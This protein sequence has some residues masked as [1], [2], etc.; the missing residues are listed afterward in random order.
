MALVGGS[1]GMSARSE[2]EHAELARLVA[3]GLQEHCVPVEIKELLLAAGEYA[4]VEI[5]PWP[6]GSLLGGSR[7]NRLSCLQQADGDG[8]T[9]QC[10]SAPGIRRTYLVPSRTSK[11]GCFALNIST[12][13]PD[14]G[15]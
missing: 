9:Y 7:Q 4:H 8:Q 15:F 1:G 12:R 11:S 5:I 14:A 3:D 10:G 2:L 13:Q 6:S